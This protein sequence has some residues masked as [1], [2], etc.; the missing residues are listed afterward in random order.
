[1]VAAM[2]TPASGDRFVCHFLLYQ[3]A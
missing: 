3:V 1:M 2:G